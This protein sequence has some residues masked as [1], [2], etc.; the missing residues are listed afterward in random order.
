LDLFR[1]NVKGD[2]GYV[3]AP[4]SPGYEVA[5]DRRIGVWPKALLA[6][7]GDGPGFDDRRGVDAPG[8]RSTKPGA[9]TPRNKTRNVQDRSAAILR[10]LETA[11]V[12]TRNDRL[13]WAA[14][15][16]GEMLAEGAIALEVAAQLLANA[17][18]AT[19][20]VRDDGA[21]AVLATIRSGLR[22]GL[23]K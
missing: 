1:L 20:L 23:G 22:A 12:G 17:A 16:F 19:G 11:P 7:L 3:V 5:I 14:C 15:R 9:S 21:A 6:M 4:P 2:G 18:G 13:F 10:V 8:F